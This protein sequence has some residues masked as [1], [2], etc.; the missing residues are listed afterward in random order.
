MAWPQLKQFAAYI[1]IAIEEME[2][3]LGPIPRTGLT[4]IELQD[5]ARSIIKD[6]M[7]HK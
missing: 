4:D 7:V 5:Q 6:F 1:V 2:R 3:Q